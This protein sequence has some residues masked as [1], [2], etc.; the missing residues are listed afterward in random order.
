LLGK[1]SFRSRSYVTR[2]HRSYYITTNMAKLLHCILT[3][4]ICFIYYLFFLTYKEKRLVNTFSYLTTYYFWWKKTKYHQ[5]IYKRIVTVSH[6][7]TKIWFRLYQN[8]CCTILFYSIC[9][10]FFYWLQFLYNLF[11]TCVFKL[12]FCVFFLKLSFKSF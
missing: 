2:N 10:I 6:I 11:Y 3:F 4:I 12:F 1:R 7:Q 9:Y 8:Y 5:I